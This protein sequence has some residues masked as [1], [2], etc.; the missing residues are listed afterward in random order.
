M[1]QNKAKETNEIC[2]ESGV[3]KDDCR[4]SECDTILFNI[5]TPMMEA[6][7]INEVSKKLGNLWKFID[8]LETGGFEITVSSDGSTLRIYPPL[9]NDCYWTQ[10]RG[11]GHPALV[12]WGVKAGLLCESCAKISETDAKDR[13]LYY[14]DLFTYIDFNLETGRIPSEFKS[15]LPLTEEFCEARSL[16]FEVIKNRLNA[17]G[18]YD[19]GEVMLNCMWIVPWFNRLPKKID[20]EGTLIKN[21]EDEDNDHE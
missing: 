2:S 3:L 13:P 20:Q 6:R 12:D 4:C 7:N 11:C 8:R 1:T 18:G 15:E 5:Q 10:C 19:P 14:D 17:T 9:V 16:D 21:T